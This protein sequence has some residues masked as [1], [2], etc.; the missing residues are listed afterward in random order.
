[1]LRDKYNAKVEYAYLS[2]VDYDNV[3]G[4]YTYNFTTSNAFNGVAITDDVLTTAKVITTKDFSDLFGQ[5]VAV[6]YKDAKTVYGMYSESTVLASDIVGNVTNTNGGAIVGTETQIKIGDVKF[7]MNTTMS[8]AGVYTYNNSTA[9]ALPANGYFSIDAIDHD[10]DNKIDCFVVYPVDVQKVTYVGTNSIN[11]GN[12]YSYD[13]D[14]KLYSYNNNDY[15]FPSVSKDD[16]VAIN[17]Y[18]VDDMT[19]K[20]ATLD[21]VQGEVTAMKGNDVQINGVWYEEA[22]DN[23]DTPAV[24]DTVALTV[25]GN[26]YF[27]VKTVDG[28]SLDNML[29]VLDAGNNSSGLGSGVEA[30]VMYAKDGTVATISKVSKVDNVSATVP[31]SGSAAKP[32][33]SAVTDYDTAGNVVVGALYTY[34]EKDGAVELSKLGDNVIGDSK[35]AK[36]ATTF[37][38]NNTKPLV[39]NKVIS[40]DAVVMV[41]DSANDKYSFT[42]GAVL[43]TWKTSFGDTAQYLYDTIN[44]VLTVTAVAL[45]D[46]TD[47]PGV[48]GTTG[49]GYVTANAYY[50]EIDDTDYAVLTIW[51]ADGE[52][53]DVKAESIYNDSTTCVDPSSANVKTFAAAK[54]GAFV[55]F[56]KLANGNISDLTPITGAYALTGT[57]VNKDNKTE[58]TLK[59]NGGVAAAG[60]TV[61]KDTQIIYVNTDKKTGAEG[62]GN[63]S[64]SL[65]TETAV[66]GTYI[67][68]VVAKATNGDADVVFVDVNNKLDAS[69]ANSVVTVNYGV[70]AITT[71]SSNAQLVFRV[72]GNYLSAN[73]IAGLGIADEAISISLD[74][75]VKPLVVGTDSNYPW[76]GR[77]TCILQGTKWNAADPTDTSFTS[78]YGTDAGFMKVHTGANFSAG[79]VTVTITGNENFNFVSDGAYTVS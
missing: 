63:L 39:D 49:Y 68:N 75:T 1:M 79:S 37:V 29:M 2:N 57:Y 59:G 16:W 4:E 11:A 38:A 10:G 71:T 72:N 41:Y 26:Y 22:M 53:K 8:A 20:V 34:K 27:N 19:R 64:K 67:L 70:A 46:D 33:P 3:K 74:S 78:K 45:Y 52:M 56:E 66:K 36:S 30:K 24:G 77:A 76:N 21:E 7:K 47:I 51:T 12:S 40:D 55:S 31:M 61:T 14:S 18:G 42:T 13:E 58:L 25:I 23:G 65:A 48:S 73:E 69:V 28:K 35:F 43:K 5:K 60:M 6:V 50:T 15:S 32:N 54:K 44:G 9:G 17:Q 62:D